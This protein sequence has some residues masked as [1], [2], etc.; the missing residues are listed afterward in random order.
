MLYMTIL[1]IGIKSLEIDEV[2]DVRMS[3][4][5]MITLIEVVS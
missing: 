1:E 3:S 2:R 4:G 5:T